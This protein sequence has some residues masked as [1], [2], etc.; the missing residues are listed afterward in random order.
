MAD[1]E[2][3]SGDEMSEAPATPE[4]AKPEKEAKPAKGKS[5]FITVNVT[6]DELKA[7]AAESKPKAAP[8]APPAK[9]AG[10]FA[11]VSTPAV[12]PAAPASG[13]MGA[14]PASSS[15]AAGSGENFMGPVGDLLAN[16][17]VKERQTQ[18]I[19]TFSAIGVITLCCICPCVFWVGS[20]ALGALGSM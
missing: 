6:G 3:K 19:I 18:Q 13:S 4:P 7:A 9:D 17:G 8:A 16:M 12:A 11:E 1:E 2:N 5:D 15:A 10:G 14:A 20:M